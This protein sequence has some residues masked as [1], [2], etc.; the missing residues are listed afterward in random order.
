MG[1]FCSREGLATTRRVVGD[2]LVLLFFFYFST[3]GGEE[4]GLFFSFCGEDEPARSQH[5]MVIVPAAT[6]EIIAS[7]I[8]N[9]GS[10]SIQQ[11]EHLRVRACVQ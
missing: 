11:A 7:W 5:S 3:L 6:A 4:G 2:G 8:G 9:P 10:S 1:L